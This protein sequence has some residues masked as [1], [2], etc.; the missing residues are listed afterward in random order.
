MLCSYDNKNVFKLGFNTGVA[1]Q[2]D[3]WAA[4]GKFSKN[5][6]FLG[7]FLTKTVEK[8]QEYRKISEF[9]FKIG[10]QKSFSGPHAARGPG[11][12]LLY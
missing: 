4:F 1:N 7:Q 3:L 10:P 9:Q 8:H 12:P 6:D 11:W 2:M 5:T